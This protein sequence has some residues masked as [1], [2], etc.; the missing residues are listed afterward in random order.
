MGRVKISFERR[1]SRD[2]CLTMLS[3]G[4]EISRP[5]PTRFA[6][7]KYTPDPD[8]LVPR[9][10][11]QNPRMKV[12]N[13]PTGSVD[14]AL[15]K[16]RSSYQKHRAPPRSMTLFDSLE[17]NCNW[18]DPIEN[19]ISRWW[20]LKER[21]KKERKNWNFS[22]NIFLCFLRVRK[23]GWFFLIWKIVCKNIAR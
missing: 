17:K 14:P 16:K 7:E 11:V 10:R 21:N 18:S 9:P 20:L 2:R 8:S 5:R 15:L 1:T 19:E 4:Q 23:N 13:E 22:T 12:E 3:S 6:Q